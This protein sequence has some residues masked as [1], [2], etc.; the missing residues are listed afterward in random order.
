M[1]HSF[2]ALSIYLY[3]V[4][5][6]NGCAIPLSE[7]SCISVGEKK[8]IESWYMHDDCDDYFGLDR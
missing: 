1:K 6:L 8:K 3:F 4:V 7:N 2:K 5:M